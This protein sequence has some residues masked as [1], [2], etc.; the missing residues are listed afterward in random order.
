VQL[1]D[2]IAPHESRLRR[3]IRWNLPGNRLWYLPANK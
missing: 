3:K 1:R 2:D